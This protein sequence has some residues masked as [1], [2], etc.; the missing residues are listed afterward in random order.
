LVKWHLAVKFGAVKEV[1]LLQ[2]VICFDKLSE[3]YWFI[4]IRLALFPSKKRWMEM[5]RCI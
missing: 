2:E 1:N 4:M 3:C 5:P